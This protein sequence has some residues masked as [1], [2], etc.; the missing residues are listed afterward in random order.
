MELKSVIRHLSLV[1]H[2]P[3][4]WIARELGLHRD[5]VRRALKD[6]EPPHYQGVQARASPVLGPVKDFID[7]ILRTDQDAPRKQRHNAQRIFERLVDEKQFEGSGSH[8]RRYVA[9]RRWELG[10]TRPNVSI[11]IAHPPNGQAQADWGHAVVVLAGQR[12][13]L[14]FF[15]LRL[16]HST[17]P[18]CCAMPTERQEAFFE[19]HQRCFLH[20]DGVPGKITYDNLRTAVQK[21][22]P[23]HDRVEHPAFLAFRDHFN[24]E[25]FFCNRQA[26]HEKGSVE[27]LV[28]YCQRHFFTPVPYGQDLDQINAVLLDR[29]R[30]MD[31]HKI[32]GRVD[33][34]TV[35][36]AFAAER[37]TLRSL[38]TYP[39]D[40]CRRVDCRANSLSQ[41]VF[42]R[43][44]YSV[45]VLYAL[46]PLLLKAYVDRIEIYYG[47]EK[48]AEHRRSY[49]PGEEM[50]NPLHYVPELPK[51][52][53]ALD[54]GKPF[55]NWVLPEIFG[56][57]RKAVG[58]RGYIRLLQELP[59]RPV[60]QV[61]QVLNL[62][63]SCNVPISVDGVLRL[64]EQMHP[65]G[66]RRLDLSHRPELQAVQIPAPKLEAY[67]Q[68]AG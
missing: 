31:E 50:L 33:G 27:N 11:P 17:R 7:E 60:E 55:Q 56:R 57:F 21:I 52:P 58:T 54:C 45:P 16:V 5:T 10:L 46:R 38:P 12:V 41:I 25:S 43:C 65:I 44:R 62:A 23:G 22:L 24:F 35:G 64:L 48:I 36:Q 28:G 37:S 29:C 40:C 68:L 66:P 1:Q 51:K 20:L 2:K 8:V 39:F 63:F 15:A 30:R 53:G 13:K 34:Q 61:A 59:R 4:R 3:I 32:A 26:G 42:E 49:R 9:R 14:P 67:D 19:A 6:P 18:F 47:R